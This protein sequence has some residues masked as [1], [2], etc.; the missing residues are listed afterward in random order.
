MRFI[1]SAVPVVTLGLL[2]FAGFHL[3]GFG[4]C[5]DGGALTATS[6]ASLGEAANVAPTGHPGDDCYCCSRTVQTEVV[7]SLGPDS[8]DVPVSEGRRPSVRQH[9]S[10]PPYHPPL[11]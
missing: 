8:I 6:Q 4:A 2:L 10:I 11:I 3:L 7:A 1:R 9:P 5:D